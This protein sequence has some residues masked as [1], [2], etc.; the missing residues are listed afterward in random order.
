M[1]PMPNIVT[2]AAKN[3]KIKNVHLPINELITN[4]NGLFFKILNLHTH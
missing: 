1:I 4:G 3:Y 2:N